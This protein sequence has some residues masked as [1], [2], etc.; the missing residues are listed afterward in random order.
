MHVVALKHHEHH[1][2]A[3]GCRTE[4]LEKTRISQ[5]A[6]IAH[7]E[8][9]DPHAGAFRSHGG[10]Q[11]LVW[12][13][14]QFG[15]RIS[16]HHRIPVLQVSRVAEAI[17]V[18]VHRDHGLVDISFVR[19]FAQHLQS[20]NG[21][22]RPACRTV[23][24]KVDLRQGFVGLARPDGIGLACLQC[25]LRSDRSEIELGHATRNFDHRRESRQHHQIH[26][27]PAQPLP[28]AAL[29]QQKRQDGPQ[30]TDPC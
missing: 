8:V 23:V 9:L 28:D 25:L 14:A 21:L 26:R 27:G 17:L 19:T 18:V 4:M 15:V 2:L 7:S 5:Q 29:R 16:D 22:A 13:V 24:L 30:E 12:K 10:T 3:G 20:P 1:P 6:G 11:V